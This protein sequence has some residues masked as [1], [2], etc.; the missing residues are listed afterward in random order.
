[1][2]EIGDKVKVLGIKYNEMYGHITKR[3]PAG[4]HHG[5]HYEVKFLNSIESWNYYPSDIKLI[6]RANPTRTSPPTSRHEIIT[7]ITTNSYV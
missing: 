6:E 2:F 7:I 1:M 5:E 3:N 4:A